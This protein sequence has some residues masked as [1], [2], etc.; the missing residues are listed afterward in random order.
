MLKKCVLALSLL[1][2]SCSH[3]PEI[4]YCPHVVITPEY[5]HVTSFYGDQPHFRAELI[6]YEGY[7]RYNPKNDQTVAK[8]SPIFEIAR[9]SDA[10]GKKV[11]ISYYANTSYNPNKLMG[12]QPHSF[13][14]KIDSVGQ[15][16]MVTADEINVTIP[17]NEPGY[18]INLEMALSRN[19]FMYN[20]QQGLA[21]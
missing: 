12:K 10:G 14:T 7:C 2:M 9:L 16:I 15:K 1:V 21:F 8:I 4:L 13:S 6:G 20:K 5:S 19:Q 17:N 11:N 3:R 18:Q